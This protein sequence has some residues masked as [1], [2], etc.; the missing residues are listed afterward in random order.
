MS[1]MSESRIGNKLGTDRFPDQFILHH[2]YVLQFSFLSGMNIDDD[3]RTAI[4]GIN[5]SMI[6]SSDRRL[7]QKILRLHDVLVRQE[8]SRK[9][10][11]NS[12]K[13]VS[14]YRGY[15]TLTC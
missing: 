5:Y 6:H 4:D 7:F 14:M 10:N 13:F 2:N 12:P 15:R 8:R 11:D 1:T 9:V 3:H